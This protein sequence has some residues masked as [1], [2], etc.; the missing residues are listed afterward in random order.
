MEL[1]E[2]PSTIL[3]PHPP[4]VSIPDSEQRTD[5]MNARLQRSIAYALSISGLVEC[6]GCNTLEKLASKKHKLCYDCIVETMKDAGV[7]HQGYDVS[8]T[9]GGS[10]VCI[11][12]LE[13][14]RHI[15][16][17]YMI[18]MD[19]LA[20]RLSE[21]ALLNFSKRKMFEAKSK[22]DQENSSYAGNGDPDWRERRWYP[23]DV[24]K[25]EEVPPDRKERICMDCI[26]DSLVSTQHF[27][28]SFRRVYS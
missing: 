23:C 6:K 21:M 7:Y 20:D 11:V 14:T 27:D 13:T 8:S 12:C 26:I 24:C 4:V 15:G 10:K 1:N 25:R 28:L 18:C 3:S 5:A 9:Q 22:Y 17:K 19:C 16:R 2:G